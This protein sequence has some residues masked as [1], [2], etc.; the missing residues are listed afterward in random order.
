MSEKIYKSID[1]VTYMER[2]KK[3]FEDAQCLLEDISPCSDAMYFVETIYSDNI[4]KYKGYVYQHVCLRNISDIWGWM[5][6]LKNEL[7]EDIRN[8]ADDLLFWRIV[9]YDDYKNCGCIEHQEFVV[10]LNCDGTIIDLYLN[11]TDNNINSEIRSLYN[12]WTFLLGSCKRK[13]DI[14]ETIL[15]FRLKKYNCTLSYLVHHKNQAY[16]SYLHNHYIHCRILLNSD[17]FH[18]LQLK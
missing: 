14:N 18:E 11:F 16:F 17:N 13:N 9:K 5:S 8:N 12:E 4:Y 3:L 7:S 10:I 1:Y 6:E 15:L 2:V